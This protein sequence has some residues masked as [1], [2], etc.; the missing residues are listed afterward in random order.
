MNAM[1]FAISLAASQVAEMAV[2]TG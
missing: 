2:E 1:S